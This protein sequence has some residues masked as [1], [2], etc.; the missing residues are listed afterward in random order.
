MYV[1]LDMYS[2]YIVGWT[3]ATCEDDSIAKELIDM[4]CERE[5]IVRGQRTIHADNGG[6]MRSNTISELF[7]KL[8]V[9]RRISQAFQ[10]L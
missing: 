10:Q 7:D 2:R 5:G 4:C 8:G 9:L 1:V 3:L 6:V